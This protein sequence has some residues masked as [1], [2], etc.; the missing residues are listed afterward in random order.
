[1]GIQDNII[2][3]ISYDQTEI[4]QN[5]IKLYC[6]QGFYLDPTYSTGNFYSGAVQPPSLKMDILPQTADT[7]QADCRF[8]PVKDHSISS[9][10]FDPPFVV[11]PNSSPGIMR[12]RFS[13]FSSVTNLWKFYEESLAEFSRVIVPKGIVVF[14]CQDMVS[15]GKQ[16]ISHVSIINSAIKYGFYTQD[17]FILLAKNRVISPNTLH[18]KHARKYHS[19]FLVFSKGI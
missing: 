11:G 13:C 1:M 8:L 7:I 10:I 17:I 19:Y 5:I 12:D 14:K 6:P 3:S 9:L 2:K 4:L 18:Q 16:W 15:G